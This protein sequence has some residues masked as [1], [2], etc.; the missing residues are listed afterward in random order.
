MALP[1]PPF[2]SRSGWPCSDE[3]SAGRAPAADWALPAH[4][5]RVDHQPQSRQDTRPE[6]TPAITWPR[7]RG[8]R[9]ERS[10]SAD[11]ARRP[12][13]TSHRGTKCRLAA[14]DPLDSR[15]AAPP[16]LSQ[17]DYADHACSAWGTRAERN[18]HSAGMGVPRGAS[19]GRADPELVKLS[20]PVLLPSEPRLVRLEADGANTLTIY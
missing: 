19:L 14:G 3:K 13:W 12:V 11:G 6:H 20:A 17:D 4:E 9:I 1:E 2:R 16:L 7:R 10:E 8:D 15:I 5:G 18:Q